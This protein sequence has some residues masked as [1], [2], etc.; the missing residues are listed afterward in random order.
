MRLFVRSGT[1][2][3]APH[4]VLAELDLP[5]ELV[6]IEREEAQGSPDYLALNPQGT[7]PTLVDGDLVLTESAAIVLHLAEQHPESGLLPAPGPGRSQVVG[8]LM[9]LTNTVQPAFLRW[10][11]PERYGDGEV[12]EVATAELARLFDRI[13]AHL[14][15]RTW[16]VGDTR[17]VADVFLLMLTRWGRNLDPQAWERPALRAH[18]ERTFALPGVQRMWAEQELPPPPWHTAT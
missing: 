15:G 3:M 2:S 14:E 13:D 9:F 12:K 8:W 16:L 18:S 5:Y 4:A 7:V 11:Y 1:A 17:T 6:R 10:F